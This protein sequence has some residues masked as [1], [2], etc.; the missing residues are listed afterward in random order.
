MRRE[1]WRDRLVDDLGIN[2]LTAC[3]PDALERE[4]LAEDG[5]RSVSQIRAA[6]ILVAVLTT[7][8]LTILAATDSS[9]TGYWRNPSVHL[10]LY[11]STV[12]VVLGATGITYLR[13]IEGSARWAMGLS[14]TWF[15]CILLYGLRTPSDTIYLSFL[16]VMILISFNFT[17]AR[18][19]FSASGLLGLL[20]LVVFIV[21]ASRAAAGAA[22]P[23]D[24]IQSTTYLVAGTMISAFAGYSIQRYARREFV[25]RQR[26]AEE[27]KKTE[28][29]LLNVL[30]EVIADRLKMS[31]E[32]IADSFSECSVLFAD[33][34][35]FTEMSS[36][37]SPERLVSMLNVIFTTYDELAEHH[38]LEKIKTIGDAYMVVGGVPQSLAEHTNAMAEMALDMQR[39]MGRLNREHDWDLSI[40]VG[41]ASGPVVAGVIGQKKFTY[42]LWGDTV[43][44]A[45]RMESHG[46]PGTIQVTESVY[47]GLRDA[48]EFEKRG[49]IEV[50]GK[51]RMQTYFLKGRK[52]PPG[53]PA[54]GIAV[55]R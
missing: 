42:D 39:E 18:L 9:A 31:G 8:S 19:P 6:L 52:A 5:Q 22:V 38:R 54:T 36:Q 3:L 25:Q 48:Y 55:N 47:E 29:L 2:R 11:W 28:Q 1:A 21:G 51:G 50:K 23:F 35:G 32:P 34:V 16:L 24:L 15:F 4:F 7:M 41:I 49:A 45:S 20:F 53:V 14:I 30:P 44:T 37:L 27:Q 13:K 43:N 26:L 40:R 17:V 33:V 46:V 12:P 10:L